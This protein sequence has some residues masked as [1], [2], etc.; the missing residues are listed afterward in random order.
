MYELKNSSC[1]RERSRDTHWAHLSRTD[2][3]SHWC[4]DHPWAR[5]PLPRHWARHIRCYSLRDSKE[6]W[7]NWCRRA[8]IL[9]SVYKRRIDSS[10]SAKAQVACQDYPKLLEKPSVGGAEGYWKTPQPLRPLLE[11]WKRRSL[12]VHCEIRLADLS[13]SA[14]LGGTSEGVSSCFKSHWIT[15][16]IWVRDNCSLSAKL[17]V[18]TFQLMFNILATFYPINLHTHSHIYNRSGIY[19]SIYLSIHRQCVKFQRHSVSCCGAIACCSVS[20]DDPL[21]V[22]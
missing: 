16:F 20:V 4:A 9:P 15:S 18:S 5:N 8:G 19:L 22:T 14:M 13:R 10:C 12:L 7:Q 2:R 21:G 1:P 11:C 3:C 6:T 17:Y